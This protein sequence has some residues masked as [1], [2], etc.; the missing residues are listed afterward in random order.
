MSHG[1]KL[2]SANVVAGFDN[3]W[4]ADEALLELRLADLVLA[5]VA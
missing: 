3:Q 4:D 1:N 5:E 2:E